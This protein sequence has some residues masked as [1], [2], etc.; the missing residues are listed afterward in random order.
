[1]TK[2]TRIALSLATA[3][4][5]LGGAG[6]ASAH[7]GF[8]GPGYPAHDQRGYERETPY[9]TQAVREQLDRLADRVNRTDRRDRISER[10]AAGLRREIREARE[11]FRWFN[12]DGIDHRELRILQAR[13]DHIRFQ[14]RDERYDR[15]DR[16][17]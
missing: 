1:M 16:R 10:E 12:R 3:A 17:G 11:Q 2:L 9:R 8:G 14:L 13:I 6:T 15:N 7:P 5:A 4:A